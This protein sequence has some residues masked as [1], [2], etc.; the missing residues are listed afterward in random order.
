MQ[1]QFP[2]TSQFIHLLKFSGTAN[3]LVDAGDDDYVQFDQKK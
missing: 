2:T 1:L 3:S